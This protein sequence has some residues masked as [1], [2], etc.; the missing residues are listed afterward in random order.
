LPINLHQ[1]WT[2]AVAGSRFGP[3][4]AHTI[5]SLIAAHRLEPA[6]CMVWQPGLDDWL[7]LSAVP[8]LSSDVPRSRN[9]TIPEPSP[10]RVVPQR[11]EGKTDVNNAAIDDLLELPWINLVLA[12][13]LMQE[14]EKRQGFKSVEDLGHF[15]QLQ[16]HEVEALRD[17]V[18]FG[19]TTQ[20][21]R[22][23]DLN[24]ASEEEIAQL[25]GIGPIFAKRAVSS[26]AECGG[27]NTFEDFVAVLDLTPP[28]ASR[29]AALVT[30]TPVEI[31]QPAG[32]VRRIVDY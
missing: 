30:V 5:L 4:D 10:R 18:I 17:R 1:E 27:F 22:L 25:P 26:R 13:E 12:R 16:P 28:I 8:E 15:L 21:S 6:E 32:H 20:P 9:P 23:L 11:A 2:L 31:E 14:R 3:Y 29:L 7:P 24:H 19:E